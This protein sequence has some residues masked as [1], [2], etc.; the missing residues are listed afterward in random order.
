M[1]TQKREKYETHGVGWKRIEEIRVWKLSRQ[2]HW[3]DIYVWASWTCLVSNLINERISLTHI[4][5]EVRE[6]HS[7]EN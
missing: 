1:N 5:Y 7:L 3:R 4:A 2:I 6:F